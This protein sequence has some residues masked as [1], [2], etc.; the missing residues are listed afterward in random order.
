MINAS[1]GRVR[2]T[3]LV[4]GIT[5]LTKC[6]AVLRTWGMAM[7]ISPSAVWIGFGVPRCASR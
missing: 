4:S 2:T 5:R 7:L 6:S 1:N 3:A